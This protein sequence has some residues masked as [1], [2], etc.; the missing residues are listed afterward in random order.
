MPGSGHH[1]A[2]LND[3]RVFRAAVPTAFFALSFGD[4]VWAAGLPAVRFEL[5]LSNGAVGRILFAANAGSI[6]MPFAGRCVDRFGGHRVLVAAG[7]ASGVLWI[8]PGLAGSFWSLIIA[9]LLL[10]AARSGFLLVAAEAQ[11]AQR[12]RACGRPLMGYYHAIFSIGA[13]LGAL[14]GSFVVAVGMSRPWVMTIVGGTQAVTFLAIGA[15]VRQ[16]IP[17]P[18]V[19]PKDAGTVVGGRGFR[20][21]CLLGLFATVGEIA[22]AGWSALYLRNV[23]HVPQ[24]AAP[25][26]YAAFAFAMTVVRLCAG[27]VAVRFGAVRVLCWSGFLAG[28]GLVGTVSLPTPGSVIVAFGVAGAGVAGV[29][30]LLLSLAARFAPAAPGRSMARMVLCT[31]IGTLASP[32]LLGFLVQLTTI[33]IALGGP[34]VAYLIIMFGSLLVRRRTTIECP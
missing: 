10:G 1:T 30:P 11:A 6:V 31:Q 16:P 7:A 20:L 29:F 9:M 23:L 14:A 3:G 2:N 34:A 33:R 8:L 26:G 28:C 15:F 5:G 24:H 21:L 22:V 27:S 12:E 13:V 4:A 18:A 17:A 19:V 32:V 25:Y